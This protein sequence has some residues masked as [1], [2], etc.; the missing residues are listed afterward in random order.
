MYPTVKS[1]APRISSVSLRLR[2]IPIANWL[3]AATTSP[4]GSTR[5]N[6]RR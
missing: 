2:G 5:Q 6:R 4:I 1:G 3:K